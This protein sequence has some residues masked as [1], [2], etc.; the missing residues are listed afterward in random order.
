[1]RESLD[2]SISILPNNYYSILNR[3]GRK[4]REGKIQ[5]PFP[6]AWQTRLISALQQ[7]PRWR[8]VQKN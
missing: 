5:S 8:A 1:M 7:T 4:G 2:I 3:E 6:F